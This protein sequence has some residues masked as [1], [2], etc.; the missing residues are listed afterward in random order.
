MTRQF[1]ISGHTTQ[2][3]ERSGNSRPM[4]LFGLQ[5][6]NAC[7]GLARVRPELNRLLSSCPQTDD[8]P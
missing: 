4:H 8:S 5:P 7:S 3:R 6:R 1:L 2:V